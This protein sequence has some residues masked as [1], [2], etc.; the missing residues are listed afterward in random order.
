MLNACAVVGIINLKNLNLHFE[1]IN[2]VTEEVHFEDV[3]DVGVLNVV[4]MSII[5]V[6]WDITKNTYTK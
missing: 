3:L 4:L 6:N 5:G 2:D 1:M